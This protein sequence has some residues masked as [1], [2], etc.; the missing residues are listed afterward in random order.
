MTNEHKRRLEALIVLQVMEVS[1]E[2]PQNRRYRKG[3]AKLSV[4]HLLYLSRSKRQIIRNLQRGRSYG[5]A[6]RNERT[7]RRNYAFFVQLSGDEIS[8]Q[9]TSNN[10]G[11]PAGFG[12]IGQLKMGTHNMLAMCGALKPLAVLLPVT[13]YTSA[14]TSYLSV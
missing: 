2:I 3:T 12:L 13:Q 14:V 6:S 8:N 11:S 9:Q 4:I 7:Q 5:A 10:V 1:V